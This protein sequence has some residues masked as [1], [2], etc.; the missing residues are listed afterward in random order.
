MS[1]TLEQRRYETAADLL[2]PRLRRVALAVPERDC[3][4]VEELRLRAGH[5]MTVLLPEGERA[6][7]PD[8]MVLQEELDS[9]IET[10]TGYSRYASLETL[11]H[12]YLCVRGGYRIGVCGTAVMRDGAVSNIKDVSS[13]AIRIVRQKIGLAEPLLEKLY[14]K[15]GALCSTL[16]LS[17]PGGGKTTL[18]RDLIRCFSLGNDRHAAQRVSVI[19]ERGEIA[20]MADGCAQTE[21]GNHTDVLDCCPKAVGIPMVLRAMNPTVIAVDEITEPRDI[22]AICTAANCGVSL[23]AT[24]HASGIEEL[25]QKP[26]WRELMS[27]GVFSREITICACDG[28]RSYRVETL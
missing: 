8:A 10:V 27:A 9:V 15:H 21:L 7:A 28:G 6:P 14:D 19:D 11:C 4:C 12:G 20:V 13:L 22:E 23:L 1:K 2:S 3:E 17:A 18:L 5:P 26:L 24:I 25:R 16:I